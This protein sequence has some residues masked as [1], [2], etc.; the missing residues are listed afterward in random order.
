MKNTT[1]GRGKP[2]T[3][4]YCVLHDGRVTLVS[5]SSL[6][7]SGIAP[8]AF[9]GTPVTDNVHPDDLARVAKFLEPGWAGSFSEPVRLRDADASWSWRMMRGVRTIDADGRP[10]A[11][12]RF[13]KIDEPRSVTSRTG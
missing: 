8:E 10:S 3:V 6:D 5:S 7:V 4:V 9:V 2:S 11:V 12:L 1:K 13:K